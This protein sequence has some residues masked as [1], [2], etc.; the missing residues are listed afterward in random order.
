MRYYSCWP[1]DPCGGMQGGSGWALFFRYNPVTDRWTTLP[2][3]F[4]GGASAP[5]AGGVISG[6]FYV[7][8]G[9]QDY[10]ELSVYDPATNQW[11][12]KNALGLG[13]L[14]P[15]RPCWAASCT[16]SAATLQPYLGHGG[17]RQDDCVRS[18]HRP[19]DTRSLIARSP[20][21]PCCHHGAAQRA[22][23]G[24]SWLVER[25]RGTTCSTPRSRRW[26]RKCIR[27]T[28]Y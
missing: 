10:S 4:P 24:S 1:G 7:M 14:V 22:S 13:V 17:P 18:S 15:Q 20:H 2:S 6:K 26:P 28:R 23:R 27:G 19:V 5:Y 8:Q 21:R 16:S 3:P 12:P 25:Y 11:T 9:W